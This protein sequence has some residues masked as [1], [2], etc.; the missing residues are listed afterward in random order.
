MAKESFLFVPYHGGQHDNAATK[1]TNSDARSHAA[2]VSRQRRDNKR[3]KQQTECKST[4]TP[5]QSATNDDQAYSQ[6]DHQRRQ[7]SIK[8][9][10]HANEEA[11]AVEVVSR[12]RQHMRAMQFSWRAGHSNSPMHYNS[13]TRVDPFG[14]ALDSDF[15]HAAVDYFWQIISKMNQPVYA[16][17]NVSNTYGPFWGE[18]MMN[19]DYRPAGLAVVGAIM[20]RASNATRDATEMVKHYQNAAVIRLHKRYS[21]INN[22]VAD[23][24]TIMLVTTLAQLA[25]VLGDFESH[26]THRQMVRRMVDQR[27]GLEA[28]G[29]GGLL[30]CVL[31][32]WDSFWAFTAGGQPLFSRPQPQPIPVYPAFPLNVEVRQTFNKLPHGFQTLIFKGRISYGMIEILSRV[33]DAQNSELDDI[34]ANMAHTEMRRHTDFAEACPCLDSGDESKL[35]LEKEICL[36]ALLYCFNEFV[37]E[38]SHVSLFAA[39]RRELTRLLEQ[40]SSFEY[41]SPEREC[42]VWMYAVCIVSWTMGVPA[43]T[44]P[45]QAA[46]LH[47]LYANMSSNM[48]TE[49]CL[50]DFFHNEA[51]ITAC[52]RLSI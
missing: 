4:I 13:G 34:A 12:R 27:G 36:A 42:L 16:I 47:Q 22:F 18:L 9:P 29:H 50:R 46:K 15:G 7:Q 51:F 3:L 26:E 44:I 25:A 39:S 20:N 40:T 49:A 23:D 11:K 1:L 10:S 48:D 45:P 28:L 19:D 52:G 41:N 33:V 35:T 6:E 17:F 31:L 32:Q 21:S 43:D 8:G 5:T 38:R 30:K 37:T 14:V 2:A 24:T